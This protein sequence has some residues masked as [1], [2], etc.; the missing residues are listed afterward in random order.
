MEKRMLQKEDWL[1]KCIKS[2]KVD[3]FIVKFNTSWLISWAFT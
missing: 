1:L 3:K 2:I